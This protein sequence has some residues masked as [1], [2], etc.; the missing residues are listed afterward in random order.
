VIA[1]ARYDANGNITDYL[2]RDPGTG[3]PAGAYLS[4]Q[5]LYNYNWKSTIDRLYWIERNQR[6]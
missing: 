2:V 3:K 5:T 6:R 4:A 1:G